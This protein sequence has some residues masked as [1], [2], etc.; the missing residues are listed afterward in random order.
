LGSTS[1]F[2]STR[3]VRNALTRRLAKGNV[4]IVI[5]HLA[6][7][8]DFAAALQEALLEYGISGFVA[9]NDIEPT[10]EWQAQIETAL[11]TSDA[12]VA[13]LHE[14]FHAS[15][16]AD[17]KSALLWAAVFQCSLCASLTPPTVSSPDFRPS[18]E[19]IRLR[20]P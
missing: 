1:D 13:L 16:W 11:A 4:A 17:K 10:S 9:H 15:N 19:I 12:L 5:S 3:L 18:T 14:G 20:Q 7:E 2:N 6:A 8:R